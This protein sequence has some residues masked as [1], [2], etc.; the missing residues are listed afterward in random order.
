MTWVRSGRWGK[1]SLG[2]LRPYIPE[3]PAQCGA[4]GYINDEECTSQLSGWVP[5]CSS[6]PPFPGLLSSHRCSCTIVISA[7]CTIGTTSSPKVL[8]RDPN[9]GSRGHVPVLYTANKLRVHQLP[10]PCPTSRGEDTYYPRG[11]HTVVTMSMST[12]H[13]HWC[14]SVADQSPLMPP[15]V[16]WRLQS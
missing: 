2:I 12:G 15:Q 13:G 7:Q 14:G 16:M 5:Q 6:R 10:L 3:L 1:L 8:T 11:T 9:L 4:D